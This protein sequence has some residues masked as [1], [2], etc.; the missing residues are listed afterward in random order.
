[1]AKKSQTRARRNNTVVGHQVVNSHNSG[2]VHTDARVNR[3]KAVKREFNNCTFNY[4]YNLHTS[5]IADFADEEIKDTLNFEN[6]NVQGTSQLIE[7][8]TTVEVEDPKSEKPQKKMSGW[9]KFW[10]GTG[11]VAG[12]FTLGY[13]IAAYNCYYK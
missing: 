8:K 5:K 9:K 7:V 2:S 12:L 3:S 11:I 13:G 1:M 6:E 10:I 4:G